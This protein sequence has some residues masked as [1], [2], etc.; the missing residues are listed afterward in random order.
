[1]LKSG[2]SFVALREAGVIDSVRYC[3]GSPTDG[4]EVAN[5]PW[6]QYEHIY[7]HNSDLDEIIACSEDLVLRF[8]RALPRTEQRAEKVVEIQLDGTVYGFVKS[9]PVNVFVFSEPE[10]SVRVPAAQQGNL[11]YSHS[12][13]AQDDVAVL[14]QVLDLEPVHRSAVAKEKP[15]GNGC[16][17][18]T[19]NV[20]FNSKTGEFKLG[21]G[22]D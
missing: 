6:Q 5:V 2:V 11:V 19:L 15:K 10:L 4:A 17:A 7:N 8:I 12:Y 20:T 16:L 13:A 22:G 21:D 3:K 14:D 18:L 9:G 1:M